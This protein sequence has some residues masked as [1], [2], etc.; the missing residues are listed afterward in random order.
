M[1]ITNPILS[2]LLLSIAFGVAHYACTTALFRFG[3]KLRAATAAFRAF[4]F[5]V[6]L[7]FA[8]GSL[9]TAGLVQWG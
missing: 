7:L 1:T 5:G 9:A 8:L 4:L 2:V 6:A 3:A